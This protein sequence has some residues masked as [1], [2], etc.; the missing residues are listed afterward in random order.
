MGIFFCSK[1]GR[2]G[3]HEMCEHIYSDLQMGIYPEMF[4]FPPFD[5][6]LCKA[7]YLGLE[8]GRMSDIDLDDMLK[9][10]DAETEAADKIFTNVYD[11]I[12]GRNLMCYNCIEEIKAASNVD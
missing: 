3:F 11:K 10:P 5:I 4:R 2:S 8:A 7:C 1:H 9:L 6:M 12:P